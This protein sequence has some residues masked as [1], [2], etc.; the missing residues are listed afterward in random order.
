[1]TGV[2]GY[3]YLNS[4]LSFGI[5]FKAASGPLDSSY[6][7][8]MPRTEEAKTLVDSCPEPG[9]RKPWTRCFPVD[10]S[11]SPPT[12]ARIDREQGGKLLFSFS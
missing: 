1:M 6:R 4:E 8:T 2:N 7:Q 3:L 5:E 9:L 12:H 11:G 10:L